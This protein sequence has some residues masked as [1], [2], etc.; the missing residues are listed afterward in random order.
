MWKR[1]K[2]YFFWRNVRITYKEI[3]EYRIVKK[4]KKHII[5]QYY[6]GFCKWYDCDTS[7]E[8]IKLATSYVQNS[9]HYDTNNAKE[10]AVSAL[11]Y[12]IAVTRYDRAHQRRVDSIA[13]KP[14]YTH[15]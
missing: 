6:D 12:T 3:G 9:E 8:S 10:T 11:K 5:Q 1:I 7:S 2:M 14:I 4:D 15:P 13:R